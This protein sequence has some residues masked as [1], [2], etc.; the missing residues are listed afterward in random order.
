MH[1]LSKVRPYAEKFQSSQ[2]N[3]IDSYL[4]INGS[5]CTSLCFGILPQMCHL[6]MWDE[7]LSLLVAN[8]DYPGWTFLW[9][10]IEFLQ[11]DIQALFRSSQHLYPIYDARCLIRQLLSN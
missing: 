11:Q 4:V 7:L 2:S 3:K 10:G 8:R 5:I 6:F 1:H 9:K